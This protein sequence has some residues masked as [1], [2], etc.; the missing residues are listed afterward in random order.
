MWNL[1]SCDLH[2]GE[3]FL[4]SSEFVFNCLVGHPLLHHD[5]HKVMETPPSSL[6]GHSPSYMTLCA[7]MWICLQNKLLIN[8]RWVDINLAIGELLGCWERT[9]PAMILYMH[10]ECRCWLTDIW[11][12]CS[13]W[14][15]KWLH[16]M[17]RLGHG[18]QAVQDMQQTDVVSEMTA[19]RLVNDSPNSLTEFENDA[20]QVAK[21]SEIAKVKQQYPKWYESM[22]PVKSQN[23]FCT[24]WL[25][26]QHSC[27]CVSIV[28]P[29]NGQDSLQS[30]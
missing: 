7:Q 6:G 19:S 28:A 29:D 30:A 5:M 11:H 20:V 4:H 17:W 22:T 16:S 10:M 26:H 3:G 1:L 9:K 27:W 12:T 18:F 25:Q 14:I 8:S 24:N 23:L 13:H 21:E 15:N 2:W